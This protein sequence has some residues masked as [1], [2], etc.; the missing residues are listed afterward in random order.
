MNANTIELDVNVLDF[1]YNCKC[2][3]LWTDWKA[4]NWTGL[5]GH[6]HQIQPYT[7]TF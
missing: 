1:K 5:P 3:K 4:F 6:D 2:P 7:L